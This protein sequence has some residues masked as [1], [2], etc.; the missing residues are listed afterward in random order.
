MST[1]AANHY[2]MEEDSH[3]DHEHGE[4]PND[5]LDLNSSPYTFPWAEVEGIKIFGEDEKE[6]EFSSIVKGK[7]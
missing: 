2:P 4:H 1:L 5:D 7:K 3:S 6:Y